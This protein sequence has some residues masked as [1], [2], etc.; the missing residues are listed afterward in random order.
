MLPVVA[1]FPCSISYGQ[2]Q[3][4][5]SLSISASP[6]PNRVTVAFQIFL[7]QPSSITMQ[8]GLHASFLPFNKIL[9]LS[10]CLE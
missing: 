2:C 1:L 7:E 8:C 6:Q 4:M 9:R 5:L 10:Q 3:D